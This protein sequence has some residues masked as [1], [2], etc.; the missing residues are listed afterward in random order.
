MQ[1]EIN[2]RPEFAWKQVG[3]LGNE[4]LD[5]TMIQYSDYLISGIP[6]ESYE[7][8]HCNSRGLS[9]LP[10]LKKA[11][12]VMLWS[13]IQEKYA[14]RTFKEASGSGHRRIERSWRSEN[15]SQCHIKHKRRNTCA[16]EVPQTEN[17]PKKKAQTEEYYESFH[18]LSKGRTSRTSTSQNHM[19]NYRTLRHVG[20]EWR[21]VLF[22]GE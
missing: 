20:I 10:D 4:E 16:Q 22:S 7:Y 14:G 19:D 2:I 8:F 21:S 11:D 1:E 9:Q 15:C 18:P 5:A 17:E 3:R 13:R 6:E 12:G